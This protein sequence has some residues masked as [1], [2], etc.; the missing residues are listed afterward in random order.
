MGPLAGIRIVEMAG[1]GPVPFAGMLLAQL[2]ADVICVDRP[3]PPAPNIPA[4]YDLCTQGR[5][6][7]CIDLKTARGR[8]V[9]RS[10]AAEADVFLEG[11]RPGVAERLGI[12]PDDLRQMNPALVYGRVTGW[13]QGGPLAQTAG[14]DIDYIAVTG[15]LHAIGTADR[16]TPPL[17]LVGDYAGGALYLVVGVL[18]ALLEARSSGEGQVVDAAVVDGAAHLATAIFGLLAQGRWDDRRAAN[19]LDGGMPTYDVY[20]TADGRHLAVGPLEPKFFADF[21]DRLGIDRGASTDERLRTVIADRVRTRTR[22]EWAESFEGS[23]ACVAPVLSLAEA[24]THPHLADRGTF[25]GREGALRPAPAPRFS[26]TVTE[27]GAGQA[28]E[29]DVRAA[30]GAWGVDDVDRL[31]ADGVVIERAGNER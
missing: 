7:V 8:E 29:T 9:V 15:V 30:L 18:A 1:I 17:N 19:L 6:R 12:G 14:H 2:G 24:P 10:L 16:P 26:R 5:P 11:F 22:D 31:I 28:G 21:A 3:E 23:D 4:E 20:E 13:G 25:V 27:V